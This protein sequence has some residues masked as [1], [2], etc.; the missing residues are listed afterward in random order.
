MGTAGF[1]TLVWRVSWGV[2]GFVETEQKRAE[3][4]NEIAELVRDFV[5]TQRETNE[6]I[7]TAIQVQAERVNRLVEE[8]VGNG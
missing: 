2:R 8:R 3:I 1:V 7:W 4:E 5:A 6:Q